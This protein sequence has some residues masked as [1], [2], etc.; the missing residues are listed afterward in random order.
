[1]G[2]E[3]NQ[4]RPIRSVGSAGDQPVLVRV[5]HPHYELTPVMFGEEPIEQG[6]SNIAYMGEPSRTGSKSDAD[7]VG[8]GGLSYPVAH[9]FNTIR[10]PDL[11]LSR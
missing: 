5:F 11:P 9:H 7:F 6:G 3:A 4:A 8:Q 2:G 10:H 1:M